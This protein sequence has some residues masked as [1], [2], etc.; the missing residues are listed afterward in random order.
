MSAGGRLS[1]VRFSQGRQRL[2]A[3]TNYGGNDAQYLQDDRT[4]KS[5]QIS[6]KTRL[7][8]VMGDPIEHSVSPAMHNGAFKSM[9]LD[10]VYVPFNVV[11]RDLAKAAML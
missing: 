10:Y 7:V 9:D 11:K 5:W 1:N 4:M 8:G 3:G 6:G 2:C